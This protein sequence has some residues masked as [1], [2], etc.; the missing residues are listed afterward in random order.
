MLEAHPELAARLLGAA[1]H[2]FADVGAA[3]DP[4]E[5]DTQKSVR[6]WAVEELG[7]EEVEALRAAGA[8]TPVDELVPVRR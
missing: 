5:L 1:E 2:L 3:V 8:A 6:E 4:D 7:V